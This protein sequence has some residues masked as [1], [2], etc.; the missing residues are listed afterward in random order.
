[1]AKL[2]LRFMIAVVRFMR[3]QTLAIHSENEAGRFLN[4]ISKLIDDL[5]IKLEEYNND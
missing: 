3:A 1:M 5:L 4:E 2:K